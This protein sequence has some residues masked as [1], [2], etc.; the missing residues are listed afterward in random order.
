MPRDLLP[1]APFAFELHAVAE[2]LSPLA[3]LRAWALSPLAI[4]GAL[5]VLAVLVSV[6]R[7]TATAVALHGVR[8][9]AMPAARDLRT[10]MD[11]RAS[12]A[13]IKSPALLVSDE[14]SI[15]FAMGLL[16]P[17]IVL[18]RDLLPSL[19]PTG[20][21]LVLAH[22]LDHI[23]RGD[24]LASAVTT[25]LKTA[26]AYH[27]V[28]ERLAREAVLA[29][30]IAVDTRVAQE[31][32]RA[33]ATLLVEIAAH[34]HFGEKPAPIAIDDTALARRIAIITEKVSPKP[35]SSAK[36]WIS[37]TAVI[38][39]GLAAPMVRAHPVSHAALAPTGL[40]PPSGPFGFG[41]GASD[42]PRGLGVEPPPAP[43]V[44]EHASEIQSCYGDALRSQAGLDIDSTLSLVVDAAGR[45]ESAT[46]SIPDAPRLEECL[47]RAAVR[48]RM[49]PPPP[50][51][52]GMR[53]PPSEATLLVRIRLT[54]G[55]GQ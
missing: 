23:R 4:V 7:T 39:L 42:L 11:Q 20:L 21:G 41:G 29:R 40:G 36:L 15:P 45:I 46:I 43:I 1:A 55:P 35:M 16:R 9:R 52:P 37:A 38:L 47:E 33:Y 13:G 2:P 12:V 25:A 51:L 28:A 54:P 27:P 50:L 19:D 8:R 44:A 6:V 26:L 48:W 14:S 34:A 24:V 17:T 22:E 31:A 5:W 32:P 53:E 10:V 49:P 3:P 30:E 18:P